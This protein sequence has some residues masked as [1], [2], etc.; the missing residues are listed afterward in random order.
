MDCKGLRKGREGVIIPSKV[1]T[2]IGAD[3]L[4]QAD[5]ADIAEGSETIASLANRTLS[6]LQSP[7]PV[8]RPQSGLS[9][10]QDR[11]LEAFWQDTKPDVAP[12]APYRGLL[13]SLQLAT[14]ALS[15]EKEDIAASQRLAERFARQPVHAPLPPPRQQMPTLRP[16]LIAAAFMVLI[17]GGGAVYFL[18]SAAVPKR[19]PDGIANAAAIAPSG[20]DPA[21][22]LD[23]R[24]ASQTSRAFVPSQPIATQD[25]STLQDDGQ[26]TPD[27]GPAENW[28]SAVETLRMLSAAKNAP[29]RAKAGQPTVAQQLLQ[30]LDAWNKANKAR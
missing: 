2:R 24:S 22:S 4:D 10:G 20:E 29:Q 14:A 28:S 1:N 17:T 30:Q 19:V 6:S 13:E 11:V 3:S 25:L 15:S 26:A 21:D 18:Q 16:Y 23:E 9:D 12:P 27:R 7:V 8:R 5:G